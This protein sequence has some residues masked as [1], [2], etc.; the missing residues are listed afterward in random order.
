M[1]GLSFPK[2][3]FLDFTMRSP[4][5]TTEIARCAAS[6]SNGE[7]DFVKKFLQHHEK[8]KTGTYVRHLKQALSRAGR[9]EEGLVDTNSPL[10]MLDLKFVAAVA[11]P[12]GNLGKKLESLLQKLA[13]ETITQFI[14]SLS[15]SAS[16]FI[17]DNLTTQCY[18]RYRAMIIVAVA[19]AVA[20]SIQ[21]S[22]ATSAGQV[23]GTRL[24][25]DYWDSEGAGRRRRASIPLPRVRVVDPRECTLV[26]TLV[27][28][29]ASPPI[30]VVEA[31]GVRE[32][33][34]MRVEEERVSGG[35]RGSSFTS[36]DLM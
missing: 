28:T 13:K 32:S 16:S 10:D 21:P 15:V 4:N 34:E 31:C 12:M 3:G 30:Q 5:T 29:E 27:S 25:Q 36:C 35:Q 2:T 26:G 9:T 20:A 19:K 11:T 6:L 1:A 14:A 8:D 7:G 22:L 18:F 33:G 17:V 23:L 24:R